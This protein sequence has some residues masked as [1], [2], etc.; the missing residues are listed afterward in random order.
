MAFVTKF[1]LVGRAYLRRPHDPTIVHTS[2]LASN[3]L[4]EGSLRDLRVWSSFLSRGFFLI[5]PQTNIKC[6]AVHISGKKNITAAPLSRLQVIKALSES[7]KPGFLPRSIPVPQRPS[8]PTPSVPSD[9]V[10]YGIL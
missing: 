6:T 5:L 3:F 4:S 2:P 1:I 9:L 8:G 10:G 7:M